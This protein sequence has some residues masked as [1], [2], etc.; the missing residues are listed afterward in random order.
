MTHGVLFSG[1]QHFFPVMYVP[2]VSFR[3]V[4]FCGATSL[5]WACTLQLAA[6]QRYGAEV[7]DDGFRCPYPPAKSRS[8]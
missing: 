6:A 2:Y 4:I 7:H 5:P 8:R 1:E 3:S